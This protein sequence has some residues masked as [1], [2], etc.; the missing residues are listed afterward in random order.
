MAHNLDIQLLRHFVVVAEELHFTKAAARLYIA[1][2]VLSRDIKALEAAAGVRLLNR[3]TRRVELTPAGQ[4]LWA[5]ATEIIALHDATATELR[6]TLASLVVDV[7]GA[8][9]T[10]SRVL[11]AAREAAPAI[12]FFARFNNGGQNSDLSL[13]S[14][15]ID[16]AFGR[17]AASATQ[18]RSALVRYEQFAVLLPAAHELAARESVPLDLLRHSGVCF[19]AGDQA[20]P[21]WEDAALQLLAPLGIDRTAAH[22]HVLG[23][24]DLQHHL[25][26]RN[27]PI[28]TLLD[29]PDVEGAVRRPVVDPVAL[30]PWSMSWRADAVHPGIPVLLA[31]AQRLAEQHDWLVHAEGAWLPS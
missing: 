16:V 7:V 11:D 29:Q 28:L 24:A 20:T 2:Q 27:A 21:A 25:R 23:A 10:P 30:Y 13:D 15:T 5:R 19:R 14:A 12:E 6:S 26:Q 3:T 17:A 22:P 1:Q 4:L 18:V 8:G 31:A 9:L